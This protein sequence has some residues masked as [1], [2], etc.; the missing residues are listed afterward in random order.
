[1]AFAVSQLAGYV[2]QTNLQHIGFGLVLGED[3]KRLRSRSGDTYPL[4]DL[5]NL[6]MKR[7]RE[8]I[9]ERHSLRSQSILT[10]EK[11]NQLR[12]CWN[13]SCKIC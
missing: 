2:S 4:R 6:A 9:I 11:I 5:L 3:G 7:A 1:M 12:G 8:I 10:E 13:R